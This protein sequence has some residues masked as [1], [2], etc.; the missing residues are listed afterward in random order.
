MRSLKFHGASDDLLLAEE[1]PHLRLEASAFR[2]SPAIAVHSPTQGTLLVVGTYLGGPYTPACW[3]I[4]VAPLDEGAPIPAWAM[5][6]EGGAQA[7]Y[8]MQPY[9]SPVL[10]L[11]VPDDVVLIDA[12][13]SDWRERLTE[14]G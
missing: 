9:A 12:T 3:A 8:A 7:R 4:G 6:L 5:R 11:E 2:T 1:G 14:A 10:A 13:R